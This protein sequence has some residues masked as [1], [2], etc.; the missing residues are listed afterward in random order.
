MVAANNRKKKNKATRK[1]VVTVRRLMKRKRI[2]ASWV[3]LLRDP[4]LG[5]LTR[6]PYEG[7]DSGYLIR[8]V[9]QKGI[10]VTGTFTVGVVAPVDVIFTYCPSSYTSTT[11]YVLGSANAGSSIT[12]SALGGG[13]F[14]AQSSTVGR[15][16][17]VASCLKFVPNGAA[18]TRS[19]SIAPFYDAGQVIASGVSAGASQLANRGL[20]IDAIGACMHEINWLPTFSDESWNL[21]GSA[22]G[23]GGGTV[24]LV[25]QGA[26]ST[27]TSTTAATLN[28]YFVIT[29]VWEWSPST[30]SGATSGVVAEP[31]SQSRF[32][33]REMLAGYDLRQLMLPWAQDMAYAAGQGAAA[34]AAGYYAR[35]WQGS[36]RRGPALEL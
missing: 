10:T 14:V 5:P 9:E 7:T 4:C 25:L 6:P 29:T 20:R 8:T 2:D 1:S 32:S 24:G 30:T 26:D 36:N 12:T 35:S 28:G 22:S 31:V 15:F 18:F 16:R 17:A 33:L 21:A 27:P 23:T 19:G 34:V 13:A 3:R 11:G